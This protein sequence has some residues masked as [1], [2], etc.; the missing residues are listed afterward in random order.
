L[1]DYLRSL[2]AAD[3]HVQYAAGNDQTPVWVTGEALMALAGKALPLAPATPRRAGRRRHAAVAKHHRAPVVTP[4]PRAHARVV[5]AR[6]K[7]RPKVSA[8]APAALQRV[9]GY[10]GFAT[11]ILL[12]PVGV[13]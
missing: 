11:A 4:A 2:I 5:R 1:L 3:G 9:A 10:A 6:V 12:A 7:Q 13:G 8:A